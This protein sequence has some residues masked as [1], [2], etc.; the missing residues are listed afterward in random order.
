[1]IQP[2][3]RRFLL[4]AGALLAAPSIV[5]VASLMPVSVVA[6]AYGRGPITATEIL[7]SQRA[8]NAEMTELLVKIGDTLALEGR[9]WRVTDFTSAHI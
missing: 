6:P 5:R 4:G 9:L 8:F 7:A 1:M 2:S 3:R